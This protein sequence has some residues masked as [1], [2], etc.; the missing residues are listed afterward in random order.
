MSNSG[1]SS[2]LP[3][4]EDLNGGGHITIDLKKVQNGRK[5]QSIDYTLSKTHWKALNQSGDPCD[6]KTKRPNM[7]KCVIQHIQGKVGC[8]F[9][10]WAT[11]QDLPI[12]NQTDKY[13]N[14]LAIL[15]DIRHMD[16]GRIFNKTGNLLIILIARDPSK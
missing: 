10:F 7:T 2:F 5:Y 1:P 14:M 13:E 3:N 9:T 8:Q 15:T 16:E 11:P 12:C 4:H 6:P